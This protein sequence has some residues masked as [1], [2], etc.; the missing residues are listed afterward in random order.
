[1][2]MT[3]PETASNPPA[4]GG[5]IHA[6][7]ASVAIVWSPQASRIHDHLPSNL[8]RSTLVHTLLSSLG[9]VVPETHPHLK[10]IAPL[11][12]T[13]SG[14]LG[15]HDPKYLH[16]IG[17]LAKGIPVPDVDLTRA[18]LVHD[19]PPFRGLAAHLR[20][21]AGGS[22]QAAHFLTSPPA[23]LIPRI[24]IHW[25]GGRHH[26]QPSAAA[27][28]CYVNDIVLAI[29]H[30]LTHTDA[31]LHPVV[32]LDLDVHHGDGVQ[33]AF[34]G[35]F[36]QVITLSV[37]HYDPR[38]GYYPGTGA[39][40][41]KHDVDMLF[42]MP[43]GD[44][45]WPSSCKNWINVPLDR[46]CSD[47]T[48]VTVVSHVIS[49]LHTGGLTHPRAVVIQC[50]MDGLAGDP[51]GK[52]WNLSEQ[53]YVRVLAHVRKVWGAVSPVLLLGGGGYHHAN[54]A[55]AW[56]WMTAAALELWDVRGNGELSGKELVPETVPHEDG[57]S[58]EGILEV[59]GPLF[60]MA[61]DV[62][63]TVRDRNV[64][65]GGKVKVSVMRGVERAVDSVLG[66]L[67]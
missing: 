4:D 20:L 53:A 34:R 7:G 48:F 3:A 62:K 51:K 47:S 21:A 61:V 33:D 64:G 5:S 35:H 55:R 38:G 30:L 43:G 26:A 19:S 65:E 14:L 12:A 40:E 23:P 8:G 58:D 36:R 16:L 45:P 41:D 59:F 50:G 17:Q 25:D 56:A 63:G 2:H 31:N 37:H 9:L 13:P 42:A 66:S 27:G 6:R 52:V 29:Q 49:R 18:G 24:A 39:A 32:Y 15:F 28:F 10:V 44:G 57:N 22:M 1:M 60:E 67:N 54:T 11:P 46:G